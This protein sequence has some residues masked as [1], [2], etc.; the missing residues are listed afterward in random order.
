LQHRSAS[1]RSSASTLAAL[2]GGGGGATTTLDNRP[3]SPHAGGGTAASVP[4]GTSPTY[5]NGPSPSLTRN[6]TGS[7][8]TIAAAA[9]T[10]AASTGATATKPGLGR[11]LVGSLSNL[12]RVDS[13]VGTAARDPSPPLPQAVSGGLP[14]TLKHPLVA[15]TALARADGSRSDAGISAG[16]G[17]G[18]TNGR[19]GGG[20]GG[21]LGLELAL[22]ELT[23]DVES[24]LNE[25]QLVIQQVLGSG[26][27][28][29]VYKALWKGLQVA[30]KTM[31]LTADAVTQGRHAALMEAALSKSIFHPNVVTT[32]TCDLK[33]MHV[34]SH[35]GGAM[36]GLQ[37]LNETE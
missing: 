36:T 32:Y 34:D 9:D 30:V 20:A 22:S 1:K 19:T 37:I 35:R 25:N 14:S 33:P 27:F 29:T 17:Y 31:T 21:T 3:G 24:R 13:L 23:A 26:A 11:L 18:G 2:L 28:G 16:G 8:A 5:S 4:A 12:F 7:S 6:N 15:P 10:M